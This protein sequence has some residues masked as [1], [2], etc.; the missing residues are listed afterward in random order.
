LAIGNK[1][2]ETLLFV[3]KEVSITNST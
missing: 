2:H 1:V 3:R